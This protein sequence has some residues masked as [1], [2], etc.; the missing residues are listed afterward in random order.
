MLCSRERAVAPVGSSSVMVSDGYESMN[1]PL[2]KYLATLEE[3]SAPSSRNSGAVMMATCAASTHAGIHP[4]RP[5][6]AFCLTHLRCAPP[7]EPRPRAVPSRSPAVRLLGRLA[8]CQSGTPHE[9]SRLEK[10]HQGSPIREAAL[11]SPM[12]KAHQGQL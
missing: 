3:R 2:M 1:G 5:R 9:G 8:A 7:G 10:P 6:R 11:G 12:R 4:P